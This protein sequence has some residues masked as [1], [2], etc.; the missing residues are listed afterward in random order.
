MV[1]EPAIAREL[2]RQLFPPGSPQALSLAQAAWPRAVGAELAG[3]TQV[4]A[5][6]GRTLRVG[7]PDARWRRVLHRM[8]G[9]LLAHLKALTGDLGLTRIGFS[10]GAFGSPSEPTAPTPSRVPRPL[11]PGVADAATA[12]ADPDVRQRFVEVATRYLTRFAP[13]PEEPPCA[14]P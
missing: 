6:E 3:R 7:V 11:P 5:I 2:G 8:Q 13:A 9:R 1:L 10:E 4:L 12:I 14:K